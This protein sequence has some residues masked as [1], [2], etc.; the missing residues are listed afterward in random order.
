[1]GRVGRHL[2]FANVVSLLALV[3]ALGGVSWAAVSLPKSSVGTKQLKKKAVTGPKIKADAVKSSKVKDGSLLAADF[4]AGQLPQPVTGDLPAGATI[5]GAFNVDFV[6]A[7]PMQ[8]QGSSI[9]FG[10]QLPAKPAVAIL[11]P[12]AASTTACP[13]R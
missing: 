9:S 1:M 11:S 10:L 6:A 7:A 12:G 3:I 13:D 4:M 5:R 8:I 2:N